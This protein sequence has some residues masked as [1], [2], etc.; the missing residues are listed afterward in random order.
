M[1][2]EKFIKINYNHSTILYFCTSLLVVLFFY[3]WDG[4]IGVA[5]SMLCLTVYM[6]LTHSVYQIEIGKTIIIH[7]VFMK[8]VILSA[9][10]IKKIELGSLNIVN[11]LGKVRYLCIVYIDGSKVEYNIAHLNQN[12]LEKTLTSFAISNSLM[13]NKLNDL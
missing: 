8:K 9:V 2:K 1:C 12:D 5:Y 10:N 4:L 3:Y 7:R 6:G 11:I 13:L